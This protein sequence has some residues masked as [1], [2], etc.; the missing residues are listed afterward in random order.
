[1]LLKGC[2]TFFRRPNLNGKEFRLLRK[3]LAIVTLIFLA[4]PA[5]ASIDPA[6][7]DCAQLV[8]WMAGGISGQQLD[9]L[10]REKGI[11]FAVS[12]LQKNE[13]TKAA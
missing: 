1:M 10:L 5:F 2:Q 8:A 3:S 4:L 11:T 7:V 9:H 13:T 12:S 6:P